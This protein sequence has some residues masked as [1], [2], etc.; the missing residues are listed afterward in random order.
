[1]G[2]LGDFLCLAIEWLPTLPLLGITSYCIQICQAISLCSSSWTQGFSTNFPDLLNSFAFR[3][4][5]HIVWLF[6]CLVHVRRWFCG[7]SHMIT[8]I[9]Y[10]DLILNNNFWSSVLSLTVPG[11]MAVDRPTSFPSQHSTSKKDKWRTERG[12][13]VLTIRHYS[14]WAMAFFSSYLL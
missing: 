4:L 13:Q 12:G 1:M 6:A 7:L 8:C 5:I 10:C 14:P 9:C 2:Q 3:F 11:M